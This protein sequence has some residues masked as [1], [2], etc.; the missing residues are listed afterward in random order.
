M[1]LY[2]VTGGAGFIGSHLVEALLEQGSH[3]RVLDDFSTGRHEN[4]APFLNRIEVM[5]ASL[6]D[7]DKVRQAV[8]EVGIIFHHAAIPSVPRSV[9]QPLETHHV[10]AT[11]TLN[12]LVAARDAGVKRVVYASSS[13]IYGM[14]APEEPKVETMSPQPISPYAVSKLTAEQYCQ[15]FSQVY[16][17]ETV[18]LRYFNVFGPRQNPQSEYAAVIPRFIHAILHEEQP[19][20]YGDGEQTRDFTY[21]QNVVEGNMLAAHAPAS[22]VS[23]EVFNLAAGGQTSLNSLIAALEQ[24]MQRP[25]AASY[26]EAR[27]GDIKH[28]QA[29][30][31]MARSRLG[32][33]P[34]VSFL[35]GLAR[36]V[37]WLQQT[38]EA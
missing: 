9:L 23:G 5:E 18:S 7:L 17:L 30:I 3:V 25:V 6:T 20:I 15:V 21:I 32:Y 33:E 19:I 4:I 26:T 11:G 10:N 38:A 24:V 14:Q 29:D 35:E 37:G 12:L 34:S 8:E 27:P 1:T 36:T 2:L 13:S 16:G 31:G 22:Q 28:S